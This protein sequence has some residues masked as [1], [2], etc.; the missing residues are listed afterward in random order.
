MMTY[1]PP[2]GG[3]TNWSF[4]DSKPKTRKVKRKEEIDI[5]QNCP[6]DECKYGHCPRVEKIR[7]RKRK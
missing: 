4:T 1:R 2:I 5:C 6:E 7:R 3:T